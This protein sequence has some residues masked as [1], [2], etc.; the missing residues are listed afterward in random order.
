[1]GGIT[2]VNSSLPTRPTFTPSVKAGGGEQAPV[3]APMA[4]DSMVSG[5][6]RMAQPVAKFAWDKIASHL[7]PKP[8]PVVT[9]PAPPVPPAGEIVKA[10]LGREVGGAVG[11]ATGGIVNG[12]KDFF[13]NFATAAKASLKSNFIVSAVVSAVSNVVDLVQGKS[14]PVQAAVTFGADTLAYTGI[15]VTASGLGAALG[16]LIPIPFLGTAIGLAAGMG[17][18][19]LYEKMV[20]PQVKAMVK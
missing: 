8:T 16:T 13:K 10:G 20:R 9:P 1:M 15:G 3:Y 2:S 11:G 17:L 19:F 18:G 7:K 4:G 12:F 5:S 14:T 6:I